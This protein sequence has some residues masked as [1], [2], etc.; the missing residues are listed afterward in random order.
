MEPDTATA[1]PASEAQVEAQIQEKGLNAPRLTPE[2]IDAQIEKE[3]YHVFPGTTMTVCCLTL[4]NGFNVIGE[5]ACASPENFDEKI[6]RAAAR[7][8]ARG[9]IWNLEGYR[10]KQFLYG[11]Q[12]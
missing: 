6:G 4:K 8:I 7:N 2:A 1:P 3:D 9:K 5:S 11:S 10:L 12:P